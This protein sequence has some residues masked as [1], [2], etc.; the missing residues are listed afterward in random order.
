[1]NPILQSLLKGEET[2]AWNTFVGLSNP[3]PDDLRWAGLCLLNRHEVVQALDL[4]LQAKAQGCVEAAIQIGTAQR[5]LGETQ[6]AKNALSELEP[7]QLLVFDQIL[8]WRE[9]GLQAYRAGE[10]ATSALEKAWTLCLTNAAH[11]PLRA[12]VAQVL[13]MVYSSLEQYSKAIYYFSLG[14]INVPP[15]RRTRLHI[16]RGI[17][18]IN[19]GQLEA[20]TQD[21]QHAKIGVDEVP[22]LSALLEYGFGT[23]ARAKQDWH[24]AKIAFQKAAAK[25]SDA[26]DWDMV[27][28]AELGLVATLTSH[29]DPETAHLHLAR[30]KR[31]L[32]QK[33]ARDLAYLA[34]RE[35][36]LL[37]GDRETNG[38]GQEQLLWAENEF[39][40]LGASREELW[41]M[42][43]RSEALLLAEQTAQA[44]QL[45]QLAGRSAFA[46]NSQNALLETAGLWLLPKRIA[47]LPQKHSAHQIALPLI[48]GSQLPRH[49]RIELFTLGKSQLRLNGEIVGLDMIRTV[50]IIAYL[51][52][53]PHSQRQQILGA[54]FPDTDPKRATDYFH[55][56]KKYLNDKAK[57]F[58]IAYFAKQKTYAIAHEDTHFTW[59]YEQ[60][61]QLLSSQDED[62]V[63]VA[64]EKFAGAFLPDATSLWAESERANLAWSIA[65]VGLQ[66]LQKWSVR[67]EHKKCLMLAE[68]LLE[69]ELDVAMAEYMVN[70]TLALEG[71]LAAKRTLLRLQHRFLQAYDEIPSELSALEHTIA[72]N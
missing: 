69:L 4:L 72:L 36:A 58:G 42:L 65:K 6:H 38:L 18:R 31:C 56:A 51:L 25:A 59:D 39:A 70:A 2:Q 40:K 45:L 57:P 15:G 13:G 55:Q 26:L 24:T 32:P 44:D 23:L 54:L 1:M 11:Q 14:L 7:D 63:V 67:G 47:E 29:K 37:C 9:L 60:L 53:H 16:Y 28:Y 41:A 10:H 48:Y 34:L 71:E 68:K 52:L 5:I 17:C 62:G 49:S 64:L 19:L 21:L 30:A 3:S 66:T 12:G 46:S 22:N 43:H 33:T 20:A 8:Y 50:E 35:G 27:F 61:Q